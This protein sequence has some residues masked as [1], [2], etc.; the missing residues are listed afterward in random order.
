M[1]KVSN[2]TKLFGVVKMNIDQKKSH[3]WIMSCQGAEEENNKWNSMFIKIK[4]FAYGKP[5]LI[6]D[7]QW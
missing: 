3:T 7:V 1:T 2:N 6:S 5:I 4:W